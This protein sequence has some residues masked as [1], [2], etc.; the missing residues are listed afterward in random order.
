MV[1]VEIVVIDLETM[2]MYDKEEDQISI[3]ITVILEDILKILATSFMA[4][5]RRKEV[6][7]LML[8]VL[9]LE[10]VSLLKMDF[11]IIPL[12]TNAKS[13]GTSPNNFSAGTQGMSLFTDEQYNQIIQMLSKGKGKEVDSIANV[14]T[15]S[16]SGS[17]TALMSDMVHTNWIID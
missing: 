3:V 2:V 6:L 14:A 11:M 15:A 17:L 5:L 8:T 4:I 10:D 12:N 16:S 7:F 9:L 1:L 13:Y